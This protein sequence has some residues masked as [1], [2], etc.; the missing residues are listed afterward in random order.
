VIE[1][2]AALR[3]KLEAALFAIDEIRE[4]SGGCSC[5]H[6]VV[7]NKIAVEALGKGRL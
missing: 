1:E 5:R 6:G 7:S 4:Y 3:E 2:N